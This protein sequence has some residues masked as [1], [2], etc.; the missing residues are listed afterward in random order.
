ME[1][2]RIGFVGFGGI[3]QFHAALYD[4]CP[5]AEITAICDISP[6]ALERAKE[7]YPNAALFTDYRTL[8]ASGLVDA[9][10]ICT[11]NYLHCPIAN[12]ALDAGLPFSSEKPLGIDYAE[13]KALLERA[14][15]L[16]IPSFI[17][18]TWRYKK[19]MRYMKAMIDSGSLGEILHIYVRCIKDSGLIPGRR[20]EW[21]FDEKLAGC[22]VLCDLGSHMLDAVRFF[23]QEYDSIYATTAIAV[24]ERRRE[25]SAEVAAVTT[26]DSANIV[27]TLKTGIDV[28]VSVSRSCKA[29]AQWTEF[30]VYGTEGMIR[31]SSGRGESLEMSV[32]PDASPE[33]RLIR[34]VEPPD[35]FEAN[36]S[37]AYLDVLFGRENPYTACLADGVR[38][39]AV[40]EA[41]LLSS[42]EHRVVKLDEITEAK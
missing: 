3:A 11:P 35:I 28:T 40:I 4:Q 38:A 34:Q 15:S 18:F 9:V 6:K 31:Y 25:N 8:I 12:A 7:K 14:Q 17:C 20:L 10:D 29:L 37:Q 39:Q 42:K 30:A 26:D 22:G 33:T 27:A 5:E 24:R 41:A 16:G 2:K 36:Q 1:K 19:Y 23:G 21:R 32:G 13:T